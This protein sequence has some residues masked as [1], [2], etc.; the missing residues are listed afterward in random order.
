[1]KGHS[2]DA[3][4]AALGQLTNKVRNWD[5]NQVSQFWRFETAIVNQDILRDFC[6]EF[7]AGPGRGFYVEQ[8]LLGVSGG[9]Y[10]LS[11]QIGNFPDMT[12]AVQGKVLIDNDVVHT[13]D[14]GHLNET[15]IHAACFDIPQGTKDRTLRIQFDMS[16]GPYR[17]PRLDLVFLGKFPD[18]ELLR[19]GDFRHDDAH[20]RLLRAH[21]ANHVAVLEEEEEGDISQVVTLPNRGVFLLGFDCWS[22]SQT[23]REGL[24][25]VHGAEPDFDTAL[26]ERK[27]TIGTTNATRMNFLLDC[28]NPAWPTTVRVTIAHLQTRGAVT[29]IDNVSFVALTRSP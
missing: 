12:P 15:L 9:R 3:I 20:W 18:Y 27:F 22:S 24:V 16:Q 29:M 2:T 14:F 4:R 23:S 26:I 5:F 28:S 11:F 10:L 19:N 6:L 13:F 21:V 1:M 17:G 8:D 25:E 7:G